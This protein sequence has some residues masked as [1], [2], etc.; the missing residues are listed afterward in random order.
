M[1]ARS[2]PAGN[3]EPG[4]DSNLRPRVQRPPRSADPGGPALQVFSR[5]NT[6][7]R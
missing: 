3:F 6:I 4:G 7:L 2:R 5:C 1:T